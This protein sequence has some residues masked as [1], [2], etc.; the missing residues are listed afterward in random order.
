MALRQPSRVYTGLA[1]PI[2]VMGAEPRLLMLNVGFLILMLM[3]FKA[4]WWPIATWII[5]QA[6][7]SMSKS[8]PFVRRVY[9]MYQRQADRY[10]P[11]PEGNPRRGLRPADMGRGVVG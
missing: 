7:K 5:H 9:L 6:L 2:L 4:W 1:E 8:D 11:F 10:E 3:I